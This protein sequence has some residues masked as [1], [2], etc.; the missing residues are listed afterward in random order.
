[1]VENKYKTP[2]TL[3]ETTSNFRSRS[4]WSADCHWWKM[5]EKSMRAKE[6]VTNKNE[7]IWTEEPRRTIYVNCNKPFMLWLIVRWQ[8]KGSWQKRSRLIQ[9]TMLKSENCT[10]RVV[11]IN[12]E[13][14]RWWQI[15]LRRMQ[16][17]ECR[18]R[19]RTSRWVWR[20]GCPDEC[21]NWLNPSGIGVKNEFDYQLV[22]NTHLLKNYY[23][24]FISNL[25]KWIVTVIY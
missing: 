5:H 8:S 3:C 22:L 17:F 16:A 7:T 2:T 11:Q 6:R 15:T 25:R 10:W 14:S 21:V 23:V 19:W 13:W 9:N 20:K 4:V 1:M 18:I 12:W 24:Y